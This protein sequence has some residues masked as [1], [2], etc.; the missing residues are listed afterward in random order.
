[1]LAVLWLAVTLAK[2]QHCLRVGVSLCQ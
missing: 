2:I 1:V